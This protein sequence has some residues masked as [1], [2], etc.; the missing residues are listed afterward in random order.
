LKNRFVKV[1]EDYTKIKIDYDNLLT[2]HEAI[3]PAI[4]IDVATSCDD[5]SQVDQSS[6][7][8]ELTE[9]VEVLTLENQKLKRYLT[10]A[11]TRGKV[12][13]AMILIMSWQW[14]MKGLEMKSRNLRLRMNILPQVCKSSTKANTFIMSYS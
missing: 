11:T 3:N 8:D 7:H 6:L 9:K 1:K 5:L 2:T 10:D 13:I 12:A 4:K 14:T